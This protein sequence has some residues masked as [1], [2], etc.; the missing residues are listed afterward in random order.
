[1]GELLQ[2]PSSMQPVHQGV[3]GLHGDRQPFPAF[4]ME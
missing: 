2:Q 3:M 1:M 4:L